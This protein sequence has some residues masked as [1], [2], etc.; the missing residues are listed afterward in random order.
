M[1]VTL[2]TGERLGRCSDT[3][4]IVV[5]C[6]GV[7]ELIRCSSFLSV[8]RANTPDFTGEKHLG[9]NSVCFHHTPVR[10]SPDLGLK[11]KIGTEK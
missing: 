9:A 1:Y 7:K 4:V 2:R 10:K 5:A 11:E 8:V 3:Q 6:L